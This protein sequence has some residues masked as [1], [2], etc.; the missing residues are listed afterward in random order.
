MPCSKKCFVASFLAMAICERFN[1][2][3]GDELV[4]YESFYSLAEAKAVIE[5]RTRPV[6]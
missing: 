6:T 1:A 3:L 5:L 2:K 4:D